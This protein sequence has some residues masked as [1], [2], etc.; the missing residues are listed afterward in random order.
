MTRWG[1]LKTI[2]DMRRHLATVLLRVESGE[3]DAQVAGRLPY[4]TNVLVKAIHDGEL[5][6]R[7][8]VLERSFESS[9][10]QHASAAS[11]RKR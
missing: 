4:I 7:V 5:E 6:R 9:Q 11:S 3:L 10:G 1:R 8:T 2:K